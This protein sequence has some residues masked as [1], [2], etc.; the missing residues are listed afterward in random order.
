MYYKSNLFLKETNI[1]W[2]SRVGLK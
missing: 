1:F 2:T